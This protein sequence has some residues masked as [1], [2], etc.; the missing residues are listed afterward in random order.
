MSSLIDKLLKNSTSKLTAVITESKVY[1]KKDVIQTDVPMVNVALSGHLDGG[2]PPGILTISGPSKHFKTGYL[3]LLAAAFQRKY[4]DG[5]ILFYDS[6]FGTPP[7]YFE[8]FGID[9]SRVVHTPIKD[10]EELKFDLTKQLSELDKNDRVFIGI[11]SIG[12]L[13]SVKEA[14][15]A[16][17]GKSVADMSRAKQLKS[18]FRIVTPHL[19]LKDIPLVV[20]NH[21]Y[22]E[23]GMY[24]KAIVSGGTGIYYS[25]DAI[26]IVGRQQEKD[27][28]EV[29]GYNF[30]INVEK[31]RHVKEKSKIPVNVTFT[32]G[33]NKW[34]GLFELALES[35]HLI[36]PKMGW[37]QI[38]DMETGEVSEKSYREKEIRKNTEFFQN[39]LK[40]KVFNEFIVNRY[41]L[42]APKIALDDEDD[43]S[44]DEEE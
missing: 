18:L 39:L 42:T 26:W 15:D 29:S 34:S 6:E 20:V 27:G 25:S 19:N 32:G 33:I 37:Y 14:Q 13:A 8:N 21:V 16:L 11:D 44:L 4:K 10:I 12:N 35:G 2:L 7:A 22:M 3:L 43:V 31:S 5:I 24:P 28:T 30:V 17:D 41:K 9:M 38:V 23:Q 40:D 36:K 1:G